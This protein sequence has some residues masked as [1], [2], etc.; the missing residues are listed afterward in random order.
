MI[1][2]GFARAYNMIPLIIVNQYFD[3]TSQNGRLLIGFWLS[4]GALG[5]VFSVLLC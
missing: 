5:D 3:S 2:A 1:I 4:F